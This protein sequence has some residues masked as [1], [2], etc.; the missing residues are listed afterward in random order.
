VADEGQ[1]LYAASTI[2]S[3][4]HGNYGA[5]HIR[6]IQG[7]AALCGFEPKKNYWRDIGL[8]EVSLEQAFQS[9]LRAAEQFRRPCARR[10]PCKKC[11]AAAQKLR[12]PLDR[13]ASL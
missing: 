6:R 5:R 12:N 13:L 3:K 11:L 2:I 8:R 10:A 1:D 7:T 9:H 4:G